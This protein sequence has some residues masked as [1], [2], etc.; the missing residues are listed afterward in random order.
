MEIKNNLKS[1]LTRYLILVL[2]AIPGIYLFYF[3]FKPLTIYPV[4]FLLNLFY[5]VSLVG[6]TVL[7]SNAFPIEIINAC[8]A[9]S[10]YS[11]LLILNLSTPRIKTLKRFKMIFLSFLILLIVN[12]LRI[13]LLSVMSVS[14][15]PLFE[16]THKFLWYFVSTLFVVGIW[17]WEVRYFKIKQ[18]PFYSDLKYF[19]KQIKKKN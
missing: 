14:N 10:A 18:I 13:F 7:I 16:I 5:E 17:F 8:I 4:Y 9:G 3:L 1:I 6:S 12:I 15:S 19:I 2:V 11:L